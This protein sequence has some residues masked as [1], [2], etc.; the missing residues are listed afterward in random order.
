[1]KNNDAPLVLEGLTVSFDG[2]R[3]LEDVSFDV[4]PN[5][6]VALLGPNG[7]GKSTL[8]RAVLGLVRPE[9]GSVRI[10]GE[11]PEK[12]RRFI[13]YL[14]QYAL[15]D[16]DFP[17]N[18]LDMA[19]MGRYQ[20]MGRRYTHADRDAVR[21][22]LA[23]VGVGH[24]WDRPIRALSGGERQRALLARALAREP[25]ILLLDEPTA[26]IDP[27]GE[28]AFYDLI[29][30]LRKEMAIVMVTHDVG[31][32]SE[33]IEKMACINRR[34]LHYGPAMEGLDKMHEIYHRPV[35]TV[36]HRDAGVENGTHHHGHV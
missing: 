11:L 18:V 35:K 20:G 17:I 29:E 12:G 9:S 5:D 31:V 21:R 15:F 33:R 1:M 16:K 34:L 14:P 2:V 28:A 27:E 10:F 24:L 19:L 25:R 3:I 26:S 13:G 4:Q 36:K 7:A 23:T 6:V 8:L 32:V 30:G 22:A